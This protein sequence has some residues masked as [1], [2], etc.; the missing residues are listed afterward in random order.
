MER[1]TSIEALANR[2]KSLQERKDRH[3]KVKDKLR[4]IILQVMD[5]AGLPTIKEPHVT[6][7]VSN[8]AAEVHIMEEAKIPARFWIP[9]D[10]KLDKK[11]LGEAL[12]EGEEI[13]GAQLGNGRINLTIRRK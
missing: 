2:I 5:N 11:A 9:Q 8:L 12:K 7:S 6:I 4:T 13:E 10:P 1:E 3:E